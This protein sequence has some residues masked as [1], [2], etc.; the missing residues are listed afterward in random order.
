MIRESGYV[1]EAEIDKRVQAQL[2]ATRMELQQQAQNLASSLQP[3]ADAV[4]QQYTAASAAAVPEVSGGEID[5]E[6]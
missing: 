1:R 5:M 3:S 4:A 6:A 2:S